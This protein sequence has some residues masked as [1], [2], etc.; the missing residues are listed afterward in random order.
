MVTHDP[1]FADNAE[2]SVQLFDG[3]VLEESCKAGLLQNE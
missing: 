3:R 1:R 2:R